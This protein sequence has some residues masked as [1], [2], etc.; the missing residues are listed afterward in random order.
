MSTDD[1]CGIWFPGKVVDLNLCEGEEKMTVEYTTDEIK[2]NIKANKI[3]PAAQTTDQK[4][5]QMMDYVDVYYNNGW[6]KGQVKMVLGD[7][8]YSV[9]LGN[10]ME[11]MQFKPSEMRI[12]REWEDG[13]WT[14]ADEGLPEMQNQNPSQQ[15]H[16]AEV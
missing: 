3:R 15:D 1:S 16:V 9:C 5:F 14:M 6:S 13:V 4:S 8:T 2:S 11:V 10:S 7:N 12:H